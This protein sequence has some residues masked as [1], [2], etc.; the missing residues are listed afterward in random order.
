M[1]ATIPLGRLL[2][3][4]HLIAA[5]RYRRH[6]AEFGFSPGEAR[7]LLSVLDAPGTTPSA[8]AATVDID[9]PTATGIVERLVAGSYLRRE[10]DPR[11]RRRLLLFATPQ[12]EA[13]RPR[14]QAARQASESEL[15]A[16]L[17]PDAAALLRDLL[18]RFLEADARHAENGTARAGRQ[19]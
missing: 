8:L 18:T 2:R 11:D 13:L 9:P 7:L 15:M 6:L 10:P 19:A 1:E 3:R 17:G 16:L 5:R 12:G 14:I 4:A